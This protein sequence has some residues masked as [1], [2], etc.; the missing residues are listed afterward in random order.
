MIHMVFM[1]LEDGFLTDA[2]FGEYCET[3]RTIAEELP[4]EVKRAEVF[5]NC[6]D[7]EQNMDLLIRLELKNEASLSKYLQNPHHIAIGKKMNPHVVKIASFD[8][9]A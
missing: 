4:E 7:R 6:V 3:F 8:Y 9:R 2:V 1:K 5:R